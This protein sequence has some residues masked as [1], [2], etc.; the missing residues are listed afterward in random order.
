LHGIVLGWMV[1]EGGAGLPLLKGAPAGLM[2]K[3]AEAPM[4]TPPA[5]VA[6]WMS[7]GRMT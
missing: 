6:F 5:S 7:T 4:A 1:A 2:M 3:L